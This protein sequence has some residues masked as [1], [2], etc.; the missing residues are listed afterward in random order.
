MKAKKSAHKKRHKTK[1]RKMELYKKASEKIAMESTVD[2]H[3]TKLPC[4]KFL[5][6]FFFRKLYNVTM[7][8]LKILT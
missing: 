1:S 3:E 4:G 7:R 5:Y 6:F 8:I 2:E